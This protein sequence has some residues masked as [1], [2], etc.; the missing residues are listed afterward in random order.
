MFNIEIGMT[1][2]AIAANSPNSRL[3][4]TRRHVLCAALS[5]IWDFWT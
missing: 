3:A 5:G 2:A 4:R 1:T